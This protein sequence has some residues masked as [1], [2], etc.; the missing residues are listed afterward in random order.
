MAQAVD[1]VAHHEAHGAGVI[2]GPDRLGTVSALRVIE[3][4]RDEIERVVPGDFRKIAGPLRA[5]AAQRAQQPVGVMH[6]LGVA[7]DLG[8]D[9]AERVVVVLGP[10]YAPDGALVEHL[11]FERA[12]R[13]AIVRAD[14]MGHPRHRRKPR[15]D[16]IHAKPSR[17]AMIA[18]SSP[19]VERRIAAE[20]RVQG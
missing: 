14:R 11:D 20:W 12:G 6:P 1:A 18:Q 17:S 16:P 15:L 2:I 3:I 19:S 5:R 7:R 13:W 4:L 8:A 9:H 10:A